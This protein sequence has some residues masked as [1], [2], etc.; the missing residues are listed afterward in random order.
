[1]SPS[2][3]IQ[4][5]HQFIVNKPDLTL[6]AQITRYES[7]PGGS[8]VQQA[9]YN[10]VV[11]ALMTKFKLSLGQIHGIFTINGHERIDPAE[12]FYGAGVRRAFMCRGTPEEMT[13]AIRLAVAAGRCSADRASA[14][15][16][17]WFGL[18]CNSLVGNWLCTSP[19]VSIPLYACPRKG[20]VLGATQSV[21]AA[22]TLLPLPAAPDLASVTQGS[23]LI[24][25]LPKEKDMDMWHHIALI[26]DFSFSPST[27]SGASGELTVVEWGK[28]G[29]A[30]EHIGRIR[31]R[32]PAAGRPADP[33]VWEMVR[34]V[35]GLW[36]NG[37]NFWAL[38][39]G[40]E[41]RLILNMTPT[42]ASLPVRTWGILE[43][44]LL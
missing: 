18:D 29:G 25:F 34:K 30:R 1:M 12:P 17:Q 10:A 40:D 27:G 37:G 36:L 38:H 7:T 41:Y 35:P 6:S 14:Y 26:D 24:S 33:N 21:N 31:W 8:P 4:R 13:D 32:E 16:A 11:Q 19:D 2:E 42:I 15:V 28:Q 20:P 44:P 5:Y 22:L 9:E 39:K 43:N 23:V 3:F